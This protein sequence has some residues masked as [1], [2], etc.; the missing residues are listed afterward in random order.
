MNFLDIS[1]ASNLS[2]VTFKL[3]T[4]TNQDYWKEPVLINNEPRWLTVTT[5]LIST[6]SLNRPILEIIKENRPLV[7]TPVFDLKEPGQWQCGKCGTTNT[8]PHKPQ[9]CNDCERDSFFIPIT[10]TIMTELW[11][12]PTWQD[13]QNLDMKK[14]YQDIYDLTKKLVIFQSDIETKIFVQWLISTWKNGFWDVVGFPV[15]LGLRN[16]G[17]TTALMLLYHFYAI[18]Q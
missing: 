1:T 6:S 11:E 9:Y 5:K 14:V 15:F 18:G 4:N 13:I 12:L 2:V 8:Y 7:A 10:D 3:P 16:S 17:K